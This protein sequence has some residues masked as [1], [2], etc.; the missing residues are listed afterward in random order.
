MAGRPPGDSADGR[1]RLL[2]ACWDLLVESEPGN[3]LTIAAVCS[4]AGCTPPTLYHHFGS[5][6]ALEVEAS[7]VGF[8]EWSEQLLK[9][10]GNTPDT[11]ARLMQLARDYLDWAET[12]PK[13]YHVIF[14]YQG[15]ALFPEDVNNLRHIGP[16]ARLVDDLALLL[17]TDS[18]DPKAIQLTLTLWAAIHGIASLGI[19]SPHF[20]R[21]LQESTFKQ[22]TEAIIDPYIVPQAS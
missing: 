6:E 15:G 3:K 22:I 7:A 1:E 2:K 8:N 16:M 21:A 12:N 5:L 18:C 17:G 13:A 20:T 9:N 19:A 11:E 14:T 10:Y 4:R